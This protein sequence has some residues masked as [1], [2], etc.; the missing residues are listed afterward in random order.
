MRETYHKNAHKI[1][2]K[3]LMNAR[4]SNFMTLRDVEDKIG[5]SNSYLS[6]I[7]RGLRKFPS[8]PMLK[9]LGN[10]YKLS[11]SQLN[12]ALEAAMEGIDDQ[13]QL[14]GYLI[15]DHQYLVETFNELNLVNR[16]LLTDFLDL[17]VKHQLNNS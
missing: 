8:I 14:N 9:E 4:L 11:L 1:F 6:Q 5:I 3:Y 12:K 16:K 10:V 7:E 17:L 15:P 2:G 13:D